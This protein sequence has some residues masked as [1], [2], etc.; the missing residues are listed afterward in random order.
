LTRLRYQLP[1]RV[2]ELEIFLVVSVDQVAGG[3][4]AREKARRRMP[5]KVDRHL[6]RRGAGLA[7]FEDYWRR[8]VDE[9]W[10]REQIGLAWFP[11]ARPDLRGGVTGWLSL[12]P[13]RRPFH[14]VL[15]AIGDCYA[16]N[17]D[18]RQ[19]IRCIS[20]IGE[21]WRVVEYPGSPTG[22]GKIA[23]ARKQT[24]TLFALLY[25]QSRTSQASADF[26]RSYYHDVAAVVMGRRVFDLTNGWNGKPAAGE[27]VFVVTH[28]PRQTGSTP[29]RRRLPSLTGSRRRSP[30]PRS[31]PETG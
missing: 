7:E 2:P 3:N 8:R 22:A 4:P 19:R 29:I 15:D 17:R 12:P 13:A 1:S 5:T 6:E 25:D 23:A 16:R 18:S 14:A 20:R 11:E 28:Q 30:P 9:E 27:H 26:M 21:L 10:E 24:Y 31:S